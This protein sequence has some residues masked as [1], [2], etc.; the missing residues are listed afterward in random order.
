MPL[1]GFTFFISFETAQFKKHIAKLY[2]STYLIP[3]PSTIVGIVGAILGVTRENLRKF[4]SDKNIHAGA[5]LICFDGTAYELA[6]I[7]QFKDG[8]QL[9]PTIKRSEFLYNPKYKFAVAMS[10]RSV[11]EEC[12][13]R[14]SS[15][16]FEFEVFGGNDYNFLASI[17]K[18]NLGKVIESREGRGYCPL[19][20]FYSIKPDDDKAIV[21]SDYVHANIREK[22]VFAYKATIA[23]RKELPVVNDGKSKIFV[24]PA[25]DFIV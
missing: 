15:L 12:M 21:S 24:Y 22:Y 17:G 8:R 14:I 4:S 23:C 9:I 6:R 2:R 16:D 18:P 20:F 3:L 1:Y 10:D 25:R 7:H 19:R 13:N 5:E 11:L